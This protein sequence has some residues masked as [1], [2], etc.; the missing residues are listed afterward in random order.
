M[1]LAAHRLR[2]LA[3][4]GRQAGVLAMTTERFPEIAVFG[5]FGGEKSPEFGFCL[6]E[7]RPRPGH[8]GTYSQKQS[9]L[10]SHPRTSVPADNTNG[11][12]D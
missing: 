2:T 8:P 1:A 12:S 6:L 3:S 5:K 9:F 4:K 10:G 7:P 11:H